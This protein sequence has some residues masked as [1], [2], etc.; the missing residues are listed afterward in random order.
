MAVLHEVLCQH[1]AFEHADKVIDPAGIARFLHCGGASRPS[2]ARAKVVR[3][4]EHV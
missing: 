1:S 4:A 2:S 3:D